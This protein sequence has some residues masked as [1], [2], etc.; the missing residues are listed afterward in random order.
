MFGCAEVVIEHRQTILHP[1]AC[2][3]TL[4]H[5]KT[6]RKVRFLCHARLAFLPAHEDWIE[7]PCTPRLLL[8]VDVSH[9]PGLERCTCPESSSYDSRLWNGRCLKSM[10]T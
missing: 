9:A 5:P 7:C 3:A 1:S 6:T 8:S 2:Q 10:A 4:E